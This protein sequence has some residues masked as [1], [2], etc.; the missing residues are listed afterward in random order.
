MEKTTV[1][2]SDQDY[3][4][5]W[6]NNIYSPIGFFPPMEGKEWANV[7]G[8]GCEILNK[9]LSYSGIRTYI[10]M[11]SPGKWQIRLHN[12]AGFKN[13]RSNEIHTKYIARNKAMVATHSKVWLDTLNA[14][15]DSNY[16]NHEGEQ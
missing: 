4:S 13:V 16:S 15:Q 6:D 2:E 1:F 11:V 5:K 3:E 12:P 9:S 10:D 7:S 8:K 14:V